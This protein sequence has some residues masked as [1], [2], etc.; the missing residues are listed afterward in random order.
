MKINLDFPKVQQINGIETA[1]HVNQSEAGIGDGETQNNQLQPI[2][3]MLCGLVQSLCANQAN[4]GTT[5]AGEAQ[6]L[7]QRDRDTLPIVG[8]N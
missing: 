5:N 8:E 7:Y 1:Q 3:Q 4:E 2:I 6:T